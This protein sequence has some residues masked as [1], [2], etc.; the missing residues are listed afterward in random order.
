MRIVAMLLVLSS[1]MSW[2]GCSDTKT[3]PSEPSPPPIVKPLVEISQTQDGLQLTLNVDLVIWKGD[4]SLT[5]GVKVVNTNET[6]I[7]YGQG[8]CGCPNPSPFMQMEDGN[9]CFSEPRPLCPCVSGGVVELAQNQEIGSAEQ[10]QMRC[11]EASTWVGGDFY[12][13]T[14]ENGE[15]VGRSLKV[16][17][18]LP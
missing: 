3:S 5:V 6:P 18:P 10:Y 13:Y 11:V 8:G 15:R 14:R 1:A 16:I 9:Y 12:Y 17:W 2:L 7:E 4:S